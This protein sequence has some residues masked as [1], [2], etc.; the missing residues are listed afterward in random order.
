MNILITGNRGFV[1]RHFSKNLRKEHYIF[2]VDIS[3][4]TD[5]RDFF[6]EDSRK[7][8]LTI[9]LAAIVGGRLNID[10]NPLSVATDLSIDAEMFNWAIRT[11]Q[12]NIVYFS[13]SAAYPIKYQTF[14][15][16]KTLSEDMVDFNDLSLPDMTYGWSKLTGEYLASFARDRGLR[17]LVFRPFSGYGP[18]QALD[19]PFPSFIARGVHR[20]DPF[21]IWG[22]G[23]QER[24]FIHIDDI[25]DATMKA[26]EL[27]LNDTFNLGTGRATD[28]LQLA[29]LVTDQVGY[30][31][32]YRFHTDKPSGVSR[33]VANIEKTSSF[34][35]PQISLEEGIAEAI[36]KYAI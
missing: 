1:G 7:F 12:E 25:V 15:E 26:V 28:F 24:D 9:H 33:R 5:C 8:D 10:G 13:S 34:Y 18:D 14:Q 31:P 4:G 32:Q 16:Y 11:G 23:T 36:H 19:Y 22:D 6:K 27:G 3:D 35:V 20:S 21:D 30:S 2:G 17:V 29:Q